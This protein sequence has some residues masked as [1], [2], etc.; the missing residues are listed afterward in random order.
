[1]GYVPVKTRVGNQL[2][3]FAGILAHN[4]TH[5]LQM[6]INPPCRRTTIFVPG[7]VSGNCAARSIAGRMWC[8][9]LAAFRNCEAICHRP[10]QAT[11]IGRFNSPV[12]IRIGTTKSVSFDTTTAASKRSFH[13]S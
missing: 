9:W 7:S 3:M 12:T 4:L 2:Y 13:A 10:G 5:E 8:T 11:K 6:R 1:M